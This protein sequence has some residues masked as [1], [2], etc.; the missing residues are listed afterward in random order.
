MIDTRLTLT[1]NGHE[2]RAEP[3]RSLIHLLR[4]L[5]VRVPTL[6]HDDRL[7]P[8][9]G[10]RLCVVERL[11]GRGGLV[12]SCSTPVQAGMVIE[13]D[14]AAV[15]ASR[16]S[17]LQL[18]VMNHRMECPTC[19]RAGDCRFQDLLYEIG[20]PEDELPFEL[21]RAPR[22]ESSPVIVRD[23]EKCIVCGKCVRLCD[24]VQGVSAIG[25][26]HRG[27]DSRVA[28]FL[29]RPLQCELCGQCVNACPVGALVA[30]PFVSSVPAWL[31][32]SRTTTCS[33]CSCG[34]SLE[35]ERYRGEVQRVHGV[36]TSEP[37]RGKLCVKGWLGSD[38][39]SSPDRLTSPLVR[40]DGSLHEATWEEALE[41][42]VAGLRRASG[43]VLAIAGS[44][45]ACEDGLILDRLVGGALGSPRVGIAPTGGLA[46]LVEGVGSVF[47]SPRS[48]ATFDDLR[49]ADLVLVL[50][51]DPTR[52]HPLIKTELV[53]G[54]RQR[55]RPFVLACPL[56]SGLDRH[57][58]SVLAVAPGTEDVLLDGVAGH[59]LSSDFELDARAA[60]ATGVEAW[61]DSVISLNREE[62]ARSTGLEADAIATL[63][64]DLAAAD[65]VVL[66]VVTALGLAGDEAQVARA[67]AQLTAVLPGAKLMVAGEKANLQGLIDIGLGGSGDRDVVAGLSAVAD[68][69]VDAVVLAGTDPVGGLPASVRA[70]EALERA[71]FVVALDGFLNRSSRLADVVLP[72]ALLAERDGT[73]VSC[74][75]VR[76]ALLRAVEP[77]DGLPQDGELL[78]EIGRRLGVEIPRGDALAREI[79][80]LLVGAA[81]AP[82]V[83]RLQPVA[84]PRKRL[85]ADGLLLDA[86]PILAHS[87]ST[88]GNSRRLTELEPTV[89]AGLN[90]VDGDRLGI[91]PGEIVSVEAGDRK[92]LLRVRLDAAVHPGSVAVPWCGGP[93]GATSLVDDLVTAAAVR[94][95]RS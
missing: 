76:R 91:G 18:L 39:V 22:D 66:V 4:E 17:T 65:R 36:S 83:V 92:V 3:G 8:Y 30:R 38:V 68:G 14:S 94:I 10:C 80:R 49:A 71:A 58:R 41:A 32:S 29:D 64:A 2:V 15:V 27:L 86:G 13:T 88:T 57:A 11:D 12:P 33:Y 21:I 62:V 70:R 20:T 79:D 47:D 28:T 61:R 60:T 40:R 74:D 44:R 34:C 42:T 90:P 82:E 89:S 23:P 73:V 9:G 31:R 69:A 43:S 24:E 95:R 56:P 78:L 6:C 52:T 63:A 19:E 48:T 5:D 93:D 77:P 46:A 84:V 59:L 16:R 50:R 75:G 81:Q 35:V 25:L 54:I 26:V 72:V 55:G 7:T 53:Q 85:A 67:A 45:L 1:I 37:N 87:G 51:G